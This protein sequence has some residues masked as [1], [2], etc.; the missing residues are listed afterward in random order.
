MEKG[1][2]MAPADVEWV[3]GVVRA[4]RD[5]QGMESAKTGGAGYEF[6]ATI[7]VRGR[8]AEIVGGAGRLTPALAKEIEVA[9]FSQ[10]ITTAI[11]ERYNGDPK[12]LVRATRGRSAREN[13]SEPK[14]AAPQEAQL[15]PSGAMAG[16][17]AATVNG[18]DP[19]VRNG[20]VH[21]LAG[22]AL[23]GQHLAGAAYMDSLSGLNGLKLQPDD[24][25]C[26]R[27][28]S[29]RLPE[30]ERGFQQKAGNG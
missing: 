18:H 16:T 28:G 10:G 17:M 8:T 23:A 12:R 29:L 24:T 26:G 7:I 15:P 25:N 6:T 30:L 2:T 3:F 21:K 14:D 9:L 1:E 4:G 22:H 27:L 5:Y 20:T 19:S 13:D 11:W